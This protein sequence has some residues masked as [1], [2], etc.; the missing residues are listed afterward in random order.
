KDV[1]RRGR[2]VSQRQREMCRWTVLFTNVPVEMLKTREV[3]FVYRLRW[4]V[5]LLFKRWKSEGGLDQTNSN[6]R[7]RVECEWYVKLLGQVVRNWLQLLRGG[8]LCN[9]NSAQVGRVVTDGL[10]DVV[11]ALLAGHGLAEALAR[12]AADLAKIRK[13]TRR[14]KRKT[15]SELL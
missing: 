7:Y 15:V 4:Q 2:Q 6:K 5:E 9:V 14:R 8:P 12:I 3:W 10:A 11:E 1:K 13:R